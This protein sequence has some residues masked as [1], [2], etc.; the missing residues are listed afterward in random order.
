VR[1]RRLRV[2]SQKCAQSDFHFHCAA[3]NF[4]SFINA[5]VLYLY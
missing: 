5:C 4:N 3:L 2:K 1:E